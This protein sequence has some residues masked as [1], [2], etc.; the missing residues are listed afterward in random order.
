MPIDPTIGYSPGTLQGMVA[1]DNDLDRRLRL[2]EATRGQAAPGAITAVQINKSSVQA[3][4]VT[5]DAIY[6]GYL[7]VGNI[8]ASVM[9]VNLINASHI[10]AG[11]IAAA[12]ASFITLNA[13]QITAG[14]I[15]TAQL[16]TNF[17]AAATI[18][19]TTLA[20]ITSNMGSITAGTITG[21][22]FQTAATGSRIIINSGGLTGYGLDGTTPTLI[23]NTSTGVASFTGVAQ[24]DA[25]SIVPGNT[26]SGSIAATNLSGIA[27]SGG[28]IVP[29]SS[30]EQGL[31]PGDAV[32]NPLL[33]A[34]EGWQNS[35]GTGAGYGPST[36][37]SFD[38][39]NSYKL[40]AL[41]ATSMWLGRR[42]TVA[43]RL[44]VVAGRKYTIS[45][46]VRS[47]ATSRKLGVYPY[48]YTEAGAAVTDPAHGVQ[49]ANVAG[50][51]TI[52]NTVG[53]SSVVGDW[54]RV[55]Y[56]VTIPA[57]ATRLGFLIYINGGAANEVQ[58]VDALQVEQGDLPSAYAAKG[59]EILYGSIRSLFIG[60][61]E[62]K[63]NNVAAGSINTGHLTVSFG[64][65]NLV[66]DSS[67]EAAKVV[68]TT[69]IRW[70]A[71]GTT[72][73][74]SST[75]AY[76]GAAC[77][78]V[79][80][81]G[82]STDAYALGQISTGGVLEGLTVAGLKGKAVM[83]SA[84]VYVP[85]ATKNSGLIAGGPNRS[86]LIYDGVASAESTITNLAADTWV[87]VVVPYT[88]SATSTTAD[89]R[90]YNPFTTGP[91]YYDAV[92]LELGDVV[93]AY[94]P[95]PSEVLPGSVGPTQITPNSL[96]TNEIL[97]GGITAASIT[98]GAG[99]L[100]AL[101]ANIGAIT[102]GTLN[103]VTITGGL[104]RTA[105]SGQRI[106]MDSA[107]VRGYDGGG[108]QGFTLQN[109]LISTGAAGSS[110]MEL[111]S[112]GLRGYSAGTLASA[113]DTRG[114]IINYLAGSAYNSFSWY[115][116]ST[117]QYAGYVDMTLSNPTAINNGAVTENLS[118]HRAIT[119]NG[120]DAARV[121]LLAYS[122]N[123]LG[124][125]FVQLGAEFTEAQGNYVFAR[126]NNNYVNILT[127][128]V[129]GGKSGFVRS[130]Y[131]GN[132]NYDHE[133]RLWQQSSIGISIGAN[134]AQ[135]SW[136]TWGGDLNIG[137]VQNN[138]IVLGYLN[139]QGGG[140]LDY[141]FWVVTST[142]GNRVDFNFRNSVGF[143][144]TGNFG[145]SVYTN[146]V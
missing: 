30:F 39:S 28:N 20:A 52:G 38:G 79:T 80:R 105:A 68:T 95:K 83:Y 5:A 33:R 125:N 87:R 139:Q 45:G 118:S 85:A 90:L 31:Q 78:S 36:D 59:D 15:A 3:A 67:F 108:A 14:S 8:L 61:G 142:G 53:P 107:S 133:M 71:A 60:A 88:F 55:T 1:R 43:D 112:L 124:T 27:L 62:V 9:D 129:R 104:F 120:N 110:R 46:W 91:V 115:N 13:N 41:T 97:T 86:L 49:G 69:P 2:L 140:F 73:A 116:A 16:T 37:V 34:A 84:W 89:V 76:E 145:V 72:L 10:N 23:L 136:V 58:Y 74:R 99:G 7:Q 138:F 119:T 70:T 98:V 94:G 35:N 44:R 42:D 93:S 17:L 123:G 47:A 127:H 113:I 11:S 26:I 24:L 102:A 96:T 29:N 103:G 21:A 6:A 137:G 134:G 54:T 126:N 121:Q 109:G 40:I 22:T 100:A 75:V 141:V 32:G 131:T 114:N 122:R 128:D 101:S 143:T 130:G 146:N 4:V 111:G 51:P 18:A 144:A 81:A 77:L 12:T 65:T 117:G 64:G 50:V 57:T 19:V 106:E 82:A 92:Q 66:M 63:A 25:N 132:T 48:F 56:T 135:S